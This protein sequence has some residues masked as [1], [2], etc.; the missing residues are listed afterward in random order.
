MRLVSALRVSIVA[1]VIGGMSAV[2]PTPASALY[3]GSSLQVDVGLFYDDLSPHGNWIQD[4]S[5][6]WVWTPRVSAGWRPYTQGHWVW[7]EEFGWLW[8]SDEEFGWA[9]YH[10]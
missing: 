2:A 4:A 1:L 7:T 6:G 3:G 10:Y 9:V 8:V 5:Y